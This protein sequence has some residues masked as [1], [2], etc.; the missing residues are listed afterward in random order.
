MDKIL[1]MKH[2]L[3]SVASVVFVLRLEAQTIL[4][5]S[6][7]NNTGTC[8]T[9]IANA[10]Y[11]TSMQNSLAFGTASQIDILN[12]SCG[13]GSAQSG[14]WFLGLATDITGTTNDALSLTLS[15]PLTIG[16]SYTLTYYDTKNASYATNPVEI[17]ISTSASSF[18]TQIFL[19]PIPVLGW[20][21]HTVSFTANVAA[22]YI[23]VRVVGNVY[24]WTHVDN[25]L[26]STNTAST[27]QFA[28]SCFT[29]A[30]VGTSFSSSGNLGNANGDAD[31]L[32]WTGSSW[33]GAW[34]GANLTIPPPVN[35][36]GCRAIFM[37]NSV[38][39]TT[40]GES[41]GV[42]LNQALVTGQSYSFNFTYVSHGLGSDGAFAP[43]I[44]TNNSSSMAG[45]YSMS[46]LN[47]VGYA[48]TT[49][50]FTF[51]ASASQAGHNWIIIGTVPDGSSGMLM[52]FCATCNVQQPPSN[53]QTTAAANFATC[54]GVCN[55]D[56]TAT[57]TGGVPPYHYLWSFT[58]D[59]T[60]T[61]DS[62][63]AGS[64]YYVT[65]TDV[66]GSSVVDSVFLP[67]VDPSPVN[68]SSN[69]SVFCAGDTTSVCAPSGFVTYDWSTGETSACIVANLAGDY[70]VT[71]TN[72]NNCTITSNQVSITVHPNP[73]DSIFASQNIFCVSDSA[74]VCSAANFVSYLWNTG[75]TS[76]CI[77]A[78]HAGN[79]YVT[80]TD[81]NNCTAV[82]NHL[83]VFVY[84][85]PPVSVS[86]NGDT[87]YAF[88]AVSYQ[89]YF[90]NNLIN[91][92]TD[93]T[94]IATQT[95][96]YAVEITDSNGCHVTSNAVNVNVSGLQ[97]LTAQQVLVYPNPSSEGVWLLQVS[98]LWIGSKA[99]VFDAEGRLVFQ[100]SIFNLQFTIVLNAAR[101][102]YLLRIFNNEKNALVKLVR[103]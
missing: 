68:I 15:A 61:T 77:Y 67:I 23:T 89:W 64:V 59:T 50:T 51:T 11:N 99:E 2:F 14:S 103:W 52:S 42:R 65:V 49:N 34:P 3:L 39:W 83:P 8:L 80:V 9:N 4:N 90:N 37:G 40:G 32:Q 1:T 101:G 27:A 43:Y 38:S 79:Y 33:N 7:E 86:V 21:Q 10:T 98:E 91:G 60:A 81:A 19:S 97:E 56:A 75:Q 47:A 73:T 87:L 45:A 24:S 44:Y 18:G 28:D 66:N 63:C 5:G 78:T 29:S 71:V 84:P 35:A 62:L 12:N 93:S 46:Q 17:G 22:T 48:W 100:S 20:T 96:N 72:A 95:G 82:S 16:N 13:F 85:L 94:Y 69:A 53:L 54:F 88:N 74:Q 25:F 58:N 6:F 70:S 102:I 41:F 30:N 55:G 57:P 92:A 26:L 31:L 36:G 76:N